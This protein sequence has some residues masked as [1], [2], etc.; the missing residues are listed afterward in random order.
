MIYIIKANGQKQEFSPQKVKRSC[1][2]AGASES[3]AQE[4]TKRISRQVRNGMTTKEIRKLIFRYLSKLHPPS[5]SRYSLR[6]ALFRL[7]PGGF[8]FEKFI[9][10]IFIS[11]G[12]S[13]KTNQILSGKC[14]SH[15]IDLLLE[16]EGEISFA[17]CKFH[18]LYGIYTEIKDALYTWARFIDLREGGIPISSVWL[19][20]NTKFSDQVKEYALCRK[21]NLLGWGYPLR[22]LERIIE[23][24]KLYPITVLRRIEKKFENRLLAENIITCRDLLE[25][26]PREFQAKTGLDSRKLSILQ[27]EAS[28]LIRGN[29]IN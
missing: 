11:D 19:I 24:K 25:I 3:L 8:I 7:G 20:S 22:S 4:I 5:A 17:E 21:M 27:S 23:E 16:K 6:E 9:A 1:L 29:N 2:K 14:V 28:M 12:Y 15:E 26:K 10:K 18:H 13:V